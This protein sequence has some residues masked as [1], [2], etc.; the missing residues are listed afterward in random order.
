MAIVV[1]AATRP[2]HARRAAVAPSPASA[3]RVTAASSRTLQKATSTQATILLTG[4]LK[5]YRVS[6]A[7]TLVP[8]KSATLSV[9][10]TRGDPSVDQ[11]THAYAFKIKTSAISVDSKL[12]KAKLKA[13]LGRYGKISV[14]VKG[15]GKTSTYPVY[16]PCS[17]PSTQNRGGKASG[18]IKISLPSFGT[19]RRFSK[20]A[21]LTRFSKKGVVTCGSATSCD[22]SAMPQPG[23]TAP[24]IASLSAPGRQIS[25]QVGPSGETILL[26]N[27]TAK[28]SSPGLQV[29]HSRMIVNGVQLIRGFGSGT[30]RTATVNGVGVTTGSVAFQGPA[31]QTAVPRCPGILA[32]RMEGR[33]TGTL[34]TT[35]DG[36]GKVTFTGDGSVSAPLAE[37]FE[38]TVDPNLHYGFSAR[39]SSGGAP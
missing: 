39:A 21:D 30:D 36:V 12:G 9:V 29:V 38:E 31:T 37:Y 5:G 32:T 13:S 18:T 25:A 22:W 19:L 7:A 20:K 6:V 33:A 17:G 28:L 24:Q 2:S 15:S 1:A 3:S 10:L 35:M 27:V 14:K 8:H 34:S 4:T 11:Q 26:A 23:Q 16:Y